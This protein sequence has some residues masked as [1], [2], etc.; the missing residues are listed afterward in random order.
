MIYSTCT[1]LNVHKIKGVHF[2]LYPG[3][4]LIILQPQ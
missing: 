3:K 1:K 2:F 4:Q